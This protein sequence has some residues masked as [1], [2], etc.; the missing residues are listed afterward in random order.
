MSA[1]LRV[2]IVG[3]GTVSAV[4]RQALERLDGV[5]LAACC[6]I[7]PERIPAEV[8]GYTDYR[9]MAEEEGLDAVHICLPHALHE[10]AAETFAS[11]GTAVLCEKPVSI[12]AASCARMSEL[13]ERCGVAVAVCLQNRWNSTF[14]TLLCRLEEEKPG[15]LLGLKAIAAWSRG[16]A[17]YAAAPWRGQMELAGGGC[18]LN[19]AVHTLDLMLQ[20]GGEVEHVK[21]IVTNLSDY[22]IEVEDSAA[23]RITFAEGVSGLFFGSVCNVDNSSIEL[24][25]VCERAIYT[26]KDYSL[27]RHIPGRETEKVLLARD[28]QAPDG[29][30]YYGPGHFQLIEDF[31]RCLA[32]GEGRY[33]SVA[34]GSRVIRLIQAIRTSSELGRSVKWE[35]IT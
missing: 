21:G 10:P 30:S 2:G 3:M 20:L 9:R 33:V 13:E 7:L 4:H 17:Y 14:R 23:A 31:Y 29:K 26:I 8:R 16:E 35:E 6:D 5:E 28:Q 11:Q 19:Q 1:P 32:G 24:Q 18:M 12:T 22:P 34:D 25:A 27:W 15:R